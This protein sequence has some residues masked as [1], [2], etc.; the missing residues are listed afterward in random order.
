MGATVL[1]GARIGRNCIV[2]ANALVPEGKEIPD[3]SLVVGMPGR[4]ARTLDEAA[5]AELT[6]GARSYVRNWKRFAEQLVA[7]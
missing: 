3:N 1:N 2:G 7:L 5:A 4:V 6:K